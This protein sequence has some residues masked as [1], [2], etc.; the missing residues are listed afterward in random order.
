MP[1]D[2][3][4][5]TA[6]Q[7]PR[8]GELDVLRGVAA[9]AV[10]GCHYTSEFN[11]VGRL[12]PE[13]IFRLGG[14]GPHLFFIISGFVIFMS[15]RRRSSPLDFAFFRF[16]RLFPVYWVALVL[17]TVLLHL[18][19][20]YSVEKPTLGQFFGNLTMLQTWFGVAHVEE[21]YW[22]LAVELKFYALAFLMLW[23]R[24]TERVENWAFA[25]LASVTI[26]HVVD[27]CIGLPHVLGI[28]LMV[29]Y[30][31][32]FVAGIMFYRVHQDGQTWLRH[33]L[34][35]YAVPLQYYLEGLEA[36][37]VITG[38][39]ATFYLFVHGRLKWTIQK[40]LQFLGEIS[41]P[42][43]LV[44]GGV[45]IVTI[46]ALS[47]CAA[48]LWLM[49]LLPTA[50]SM[51]LAW[52]IHHRIEK[53]SGRLLKEWWNRRKKKGRHSADLVW[54]PVSHRRT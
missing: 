13:W 3:A 10:L 45:G 29:D 36:A 1:V 9:I 17:S 51:L 46:H 38:L 47:L 43:Y 20:Q 14:Y 40:P 4:E 33:S 48:P 25:W 22:T 27:H 32:L 50:I 18:S 11:L 12:S 49:F 6:E 31:H 16:A 23:Y 53:P 54:Q 7:S 34:I 15:L 44:H 24:Q 39:L 35:A 19:S 2:D 30:C 21:S 52:A 5:K 8:L 26:F 28:P 42:L 41:Y 37:L